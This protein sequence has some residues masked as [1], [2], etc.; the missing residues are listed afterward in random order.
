MTV[1]R[2]VVL[3]CGSYLPTQILT[4]EDLA[5]KVDTSDEWIV[6]RTGIHERR[7]AAPDEH[8]SH[9]A[10][11]AAQAAL[12]HAHVDAQS[13]D[14]IVL[15]TST[16]DNTFPASA[17]S[18]QAGLGI[19]HGAAFDLQAVCSGFVYG[20]ATADSLLKSGGFS[21][22]LVIGAETFSRILDWTDRN[23]CVLFGDGAGAVVLVPSERPG[24]L[25]SHLHADGSYRDIL[26]VPGTVANGAVSGRP[27]LKMDGHAV[28]KFAV[29]VLA[30][31]AHEALA[32]TGMAPAA[33]DWV[34]PHQANIRIMEA[35]MKKL[36]LP[37]ERMVSTV[38]E[39]ANTSAASIPLALDVAVRD[40]RIQPGQHVLLLG[41]GGGFTWGSIL[42]RW[43]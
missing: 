7:I 13:I 3:G 11:R 31:T 33:V 23:T 10:I 2:S 18:V 42:L 35:T 43:I 30:E 25:A 26:S 37:L 27:L 39:H 4:N 5:R 16:P 22:A 15:A 17:V 32:A 21:R 14:L 28:F 38:G 12:T 20:L 40:G 41:V 24:I 8:T 34:I 9:M 36:G 6:Q 1:L 19:T 29:K